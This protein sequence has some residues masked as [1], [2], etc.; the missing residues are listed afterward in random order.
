VVILDTVIVSSKKFSPAFSRDAL[1]LFEPARASVRRGLTF[2]IDKAAICAGMT[3]MIDDADR[4]PTQHSLQ[5]AAVA[6]STE[7]WNSR[8][9]WPRSQLIKLLTEWLERLISGS[10]SHCKIAGIIE[11][12]ASDAQSIEIIA[13]F[14]LESA[15]MGGRGETILSHQGIR[16]QIE[17]DSDYQ[18]Q[19][20]T[21]IAAPL[22]R[23]I[24]CL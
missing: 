9:I 11:P 22:P 13:S 24:F 15:K 16:L 14:S 18:A 3:I 17:P 6:P 23:I 1:I 5:L 4:L 21:L 7:R 2:A 19:S 8:A 12:T 10:F 20:A